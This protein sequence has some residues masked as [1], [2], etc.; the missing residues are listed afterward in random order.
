M[1]VKI[2]LSSRDGRAIAAGSPYCLIDRDTNAL[3][4]VHRSH[5]DAMRAMVTLQLVSSSSAALG[6][7]AAQLCE[8][9]T[10]VCQRMYVGKEFDHLFGAEQAKLI[11]A[12]HS[13]LRSRR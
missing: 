9:S 6:F 12:I 10:S 4:S 8:I 5:A 11:S 13:E 1:T 3:V 7:S 2:R